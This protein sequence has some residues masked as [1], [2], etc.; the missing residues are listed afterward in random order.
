MNKGGLK[1]EIIAAIICDDVRR[2]DNGKA[3]LIGVYPVDVVVETLPANVQL[4]LWTCV[5]V[6]QLGAM[7]FSF[8]F[9]GTRGNVV[10]EVR[11]DAEFR[12]LSAAQFQAPRM[13]VLLESEG[14]LRVELKL[15]DSDWV[16]VHSLEVKLKK[17]LPTS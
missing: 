8:R 3:I 17:N 4:A 10:S 6:N 15:G 16:P 2:E 13:P 5:S 9:I 11:G 1:I 7:P 12:E 14:R